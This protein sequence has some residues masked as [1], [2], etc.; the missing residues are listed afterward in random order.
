M[1]NK[2]GGLF[3]LPG[4]LNWAGIGRDIIWPG[5]GDLVD[6]NPQSKTERGIMHGIMLLFGPMILVPKAPTG[7]LLDGSWEAASDKEV[8]EI[9]KSPTTSQYRA[10]MPFHGMTTYGLGY[11]DHPSIE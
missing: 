6:Q 10:I 4:T 8:G 2:L 7:D 3:F 9:H 1:R 5:T 11:I